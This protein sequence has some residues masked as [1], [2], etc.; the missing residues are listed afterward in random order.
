MPSSVALTVCWRPLRTTE[1]STKTSTCSCVHC[2][3]ITR[4]QLSLGL[5]YAT[6]CTRAHTHAHTCVQ[7]HTNIQAHTQ[8]HARAR[9]RTHTRTPRTLARMHTRTHAPPHPLT[10]TH[11]HARA[12]TAQAQEFACVVHARTQHAQAMLTTERPSCAYVSC[13]ARARLNRSNRSLPTMGISLLTRRLPVF[14]PEQVQQWRGH[15]RAY[16]VVTGPCS[17]CDFAP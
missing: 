7:T 1:D 4:R 10:R 2:W 12:R 5:P 3:K 8:A 11:T 13:V 16:D 15:V 17:T 9:A 14:A 6:K